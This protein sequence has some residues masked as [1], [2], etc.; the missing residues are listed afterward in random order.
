MV[1]LTERSLRTW[2]VADPGG[3]A[4]QAH[5]AALTGVICGGLEAEAM[6]IGGSGSAG[7]VSWLGFGES[8]CGARVRGAVSA[9][10]QASGLEG[11]GLDWDWN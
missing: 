2:R 7:W 4:A 3:A 8:G 11:L 9:C 1:A 6:V 10:P 5:A